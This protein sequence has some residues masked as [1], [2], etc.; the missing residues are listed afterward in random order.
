MIY[1]D[2]ETCGLH[3]PIV[4]L[5]WAEDDGPINL[6]S[7]FTSPI[8]ET[9]E[10]IEKIVE[11]EI[12]GFNLSFDWF[13]ICQTYTTLIQ[14]PNWLIYPEDEID[15]YAIYEEQ[16]RFGPC[17]KPKAA[18]DIMLHARKGPYQSTMGRDDIRIKRV[19]T[20]LAWE[21]SKELNRRIPLKEVYFARKK[22]RSKRWDI[23][24]IKDEMGN[25][26][27]DFKDIVL[28]FA[29]SSALKAL[30]QDALG[31]KTEEI[32]LF[33]DIEPPEK[34]KPEELG[35]APYALAIG[36][37]GKWNGSY[38]DYGKIR[39]H[40]THWAYNKLARQYAADDIK[41][42]RE[43]YSYFGK[44]EPGDDDSELACMV[45][46]VR[47]RGFK[48]DLDKV[49]ELRN[50]A[51]GFVNNI[52]TKYNFESPKVCR[53]YLEQVLSETEQLVLRVDGKITT[54]GPILEQLAKWKQETV[55]DKCSGQGCKDCSEGLVQTEEK[56]PAAIRAQEILDA[57][58]AKKE[59]E[60]YDKLLRAG[61]FHADLNVI[62]TRSSRM[63]GTSGL[64]PQGIRRASETRL[65]FPLADGDLH[66]CGG[67]F[68]GF[69]VNLADAVYGD[70]KL[71]EELESGKKIHGLF[72]LY[73]FPGKTYEEILAT[74]G[75]P[76][77]LD[78]YTRSKNGVFALL[79]GGMAYTLVNRVGISA[80]AADEA[81]RKW[82][83]R[84]KVWGQKRQEIF[85]LFCSM[86]QPG[87][88]GTKVEW[89]EPADYVE[90]LFGFR[91]YFTLENQICKALFTL[92]EDPPKRWQGLNIKVVRRDRE[93]SACGALRS[94][95]F[96]AA[97]AVQ[98][99]NMRAAGN[100]VIQ[101]SGAQLCKMLQRRL[102]NLQPSG[103]NRWRIQPLN[104]HD[105]IMCPTVSEKIPEVRQIVKTFINDHKKDVPLLEID[106]SDKLITWA[107]K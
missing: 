8:E 22:D 63:S 28:K 86:R 38:P 57:R 61:R 32:K 1:L 92:A 49:K 94:A 102:W 16:A 59:V 18:C 50:K 36:R 79:Y 19:P 84:Y 35:Y 12:C 80:E 66:L 6:H 99:A 82:V 9:I 10:L 101:S 46:A 100:H 23:F 107:D 62:G 103:I 42:T 67:D 4:L 43:L 87:G 3:G 56:H 5:Q 98:A 91:R 78:I 104:V 17:L 71:R 2:T 76:G 95:L 14:F 20:A 51:V 68:A 54:K 97:F 65:C 88:I 70:P 26:E 74:K 52:K 55:C 21:L 29:P 58:H 53:K 27:T 30:A 13:H 24:D 37:P 69:E 75:L 48:L 33:A 34:A 72:G 81:Y 40:I 73:L 60:L 7:V 39:V 64:N 77:E 83:S 85:D 105:E 25:I 93:Q 45:G 44:P 89:Y 41:Y 96:A 11:S 31:Y 47:W 15:Q 106:W 90:S